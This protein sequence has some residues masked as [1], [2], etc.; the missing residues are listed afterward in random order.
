MRL[1]HTLIQAGHCELD[2]SGLKELLQGRWLEAQV[3]E[4]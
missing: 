4:Q 2:V 3:L 1:V